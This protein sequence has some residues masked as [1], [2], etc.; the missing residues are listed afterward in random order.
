MVKHDICHADIA[1]ALGR[2]KCSE[3]FRNAPQLVNFL[4][5]VVAKTLAGQQQAIKGYTIATEALGRSD[6]F[7][8]QTD[9]IVRVEAG[10]LRRALDL[11]YLDQGKA[12]PVRIVIPRG[13]YVPRFEAG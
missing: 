9:A 12:D 7:D 11:Y 6:D 5:C 2:I 1:A 4:S 8:P 3:S 13:T 10:R